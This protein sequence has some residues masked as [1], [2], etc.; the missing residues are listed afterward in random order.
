MIML[1]QY[2]YFKC[3]ILEGHVYLS[4]ATRFAVALGVHQLDSRNLHHRFAKVKGS[5]RDFGVERWMARD[6]VELEEA[7]NV[8]W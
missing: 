3:R 4:Q 8:W 1:G 5:A 6:R 7:I 2:F